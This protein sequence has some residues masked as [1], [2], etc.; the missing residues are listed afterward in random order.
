MLLLEI[1]VAADSMT[2]RGCTLTLA[3]RQHRPS[4]RAAHSMVE[5]LP[6]ISVS[7]EFIGQAGLQRMDLHREFSVAQGDDFVEIN[8]GELE[9]ANHLVTCGAVEFVVAERC[10]QGLRIV[11]LIRAQIAQSVAACG[12]LPTVMLNSMVI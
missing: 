2:I 12:S 7:G 3:D 5:G 11:G 8:F 9:K 6:I 1:I 10:L 4:P